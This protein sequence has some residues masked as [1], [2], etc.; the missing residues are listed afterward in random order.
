MDDPRRIIRGLGL[1][2]GLL[3]ASAATA[4]ERPN[5]V[6]V[7]WDATRPDRL[8]SYGYERDTS[9]NL[10]RFFERGAV[11]EHAQS[12]AP[13]TVPAVAGI[14][15]GLFSHNHRCG[16]AVEDPTLALTPAAH[17]LAEALKDAGYATGLFT[18]QRIYLKQGGFEQGFEVARWVGERKLVPSALSFVD[19]RKGRPVFLVVYWLDP[20]APYEPP[21]RHDLWSDAGI[22]I[23]N[24]RAS[25]RV[26]E[27][28]HHHGPIN[29]GEVVLTDAQYQQLRNLYDGEIHANDAQF[30]RL[31]AGL[32]ERGLTLAN[33]LF[34]FTSDHGEAFNEHPRQR[35]WHD[36]PYE[37]ILDVP[38]LI[39]GPGVEAGARVRSVV[40]TIDIHPTVLEATGARREHRINGESL[41]PLISA[42]RAPDRVN[43]GTS[44][45]G[46]AVAFL[47]D[48]EY[49]LIYGR[50]GDRPTEVYRTS[51]HAEKTNLAGD[52]ALVR[53]LVRRHRE[54]LD[55]TRIDLGEIESGTPSA[56]GIRELCELGYLSG[57]DCEAGSADEPEAPGR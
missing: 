40:R 8:S 5:V 21:R 52:S 48:G 49:K 17:T 18:D 29:R 34:I 57:P 23:V 42:P 28:F 38:L 47:R 36:L 1:G 26:K 10:K 50:R 51:D 24:V 16:Y 35:V 44:H 6:L 39:A 55:Q 30:G 13:W 27:G 32:E 46:G 53:R 11:F 37:T 45:F 56:A 7:V 15:T 54:L 4:G 19:A 12:T 43:M 2:L 14:F 22:G 3:A 25:D 41:L 31:V 9:P 33:T 20:H